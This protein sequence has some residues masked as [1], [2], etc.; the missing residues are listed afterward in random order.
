MKFDAYELIHVNTK[1]TPRIYA[2]NKQ[3][4]IFFATNK[5]IYPYL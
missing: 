2:Q 3:K 5:T 1:F 4:F